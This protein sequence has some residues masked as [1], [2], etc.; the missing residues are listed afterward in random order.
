MAH[1]VNSRGRTLDLK[2]NV[3]LWVGCWCWRQEWSSS[4]LKQ[5]KSWNLEFPYPWWMLSLL[6]LWA[7]G[8]RAVL[9]TDLNELHLNTGVGSVNTRKRRHLTDVSTKVV[10]CGLFH[11]EVMQ[12]I[13]YVLM[14]TSE[15][16]EVGCKCKSQRLTVWRPTFPFLYPVCWQKGRWPALCCCTWK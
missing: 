5:R 11:C 9:P 8:E 13:L 4:T 14:I 2:D 15:V 16:G 12:R 1:L 3:A 7:K 6:V 10:V